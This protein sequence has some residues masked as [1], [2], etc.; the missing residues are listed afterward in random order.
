MKEEL[1]FYFASDEMIRLSMLTLIHR[2]MPMQQDSITTF[3]NDCI[4]SARAALE[5]HLQ[6]VTKIGAQD[7]SMLSIYINWYLVPD[8]RHS[9]CIL[10]IS[11]TII[12]LGTLC[13][14]TILF[15]P[16]IPFIVLFCH[17]I[18]TG[19][20][21]DLSRMQT[22]VTSIEGSCNSSNTIAKHHR[23]F[24]VF[25]SVAARY[26]ELSSPSA[27][28][29]EEQIKLKNQVDAHLSALGLYPNGSYIGGHPIPGSGPVASSDVVDIGIP[30]HDQPPPG[31]DWPQQALSLGNWFSFNQQ[32]MDL[33]G[34]NDFPL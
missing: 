1:R 19:D 6:I 32:M 2:A 14:R 30:A 16:F 23:L 11:S 5:N 20:L 15:T 21:E 18:E 13:L 7:S 33:M 4:L 27:P 22:F 25:Y 24:Q 8:P 17:V 12:N 26:T 3:N 29:Q 31:Q 34:E 28:M 9:T 10:V